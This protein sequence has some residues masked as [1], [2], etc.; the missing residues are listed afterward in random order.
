MAA[1]FLLFLNVCPLGTSPLLVDENALAEL[2]VPYMGCGEI[3]GIVAQLQ[4]H[5][6]RLLT[7]ARTLSTG[8]KNY[9]SHFFS[10]II[11]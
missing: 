3:D 2:L 11:P 5:P 4:C 6:L 1:Q 9:A 7:L 10:L 8:D